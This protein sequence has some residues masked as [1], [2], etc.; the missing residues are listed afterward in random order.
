MVGNLLSGC[1]AGIA[2]SSRRTGGIP[3]AIIIPISCKLLRWCPMQRAG[4][5]AACWLG[6]RDTKSETATLDAAERITRREA[7][8]WRRAATDLS[9][10]LQAWDPEAVEPAILLKMISSESPAFCIWTMSA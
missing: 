2:T 5:P 7:M 3:D 10:A 6:Q 8:D 9:A 1:K 4:L